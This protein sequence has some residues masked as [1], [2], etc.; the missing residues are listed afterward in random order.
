MSLH[1]AHALQHDFRW[2]S[3]EKFGVLL[4]TYQVQQHLYLLYPLQTP[5]LQL[6]IKSRAA[7][8]RPVLHV[9]ER[10]LRLTILV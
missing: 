9:A 6:D 8:L 7:L 10:S 2:P 3:L 4:N 1:A 5:S